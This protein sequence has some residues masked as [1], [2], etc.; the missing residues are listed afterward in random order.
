M[1]STSLRL[2]AASIVLWTAQA[3]SAAE[4]PTQAAAA[5]VTIAA[6]SDLKFALDEVVKEFKAT[7]P[8]IDVKVTYGSS[9]NF[10]AQL[11][12]KAPF[13]IFF[14]ADIDYPRQLIGKGLA[15]KESEF[16]YA[17]GQIVV[18]VPKGSK[19]DVTKAG[20]ASLKDPAAKKI[21]IA[22]PAHAPYGRAAEAAMK[23]LGVYNAVKDKLI[24]GENISQAAQYVESGAAEIGII[25]LSLAMAPAMS[26]KG[27]YWS[28]PVDAYPRLV[29]GGAIMTATKNM[30]AAKA[31]RDFILDDKGKAVLKRYG[32]SQPGV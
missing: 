15:V 17:V 20:M 32:F 1:L 5:S 4:A 27:A 30:D 6:A 22:N 12:N 18:W 25:A 7:K 29:Q 3:S 13:D 19:I 14:S 23:S 9:G 10:F 24:M 11:S 2:I 16:I 8:G 26:D 28:V 21:A 31:F